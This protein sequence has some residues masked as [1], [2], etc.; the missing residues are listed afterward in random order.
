VRTRGV[1]PPEPAAGAADPADPAVP[2]PARFW[3]FAVAAGLC[4]AGL[5]TYGLIGYH[6]VRDDLVGTAAV[7]L[8]YAAAMAAEAVAALITGFVYDRSGPW[9][10]LGLPVLVAAV[11]MLAFG[12]GLAAVVAGIL[13]WGAATGVQDSTVKALVADLVPRHRRATAYGL[14]AAVQGAGALVGGVAAGALYQHSRIALIVAVAVTQA[15][16]LLILLLLQ[17]MRPAAVGRADPARGRQ[18]GPGDH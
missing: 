3:W 2:L 4:T 5:V 1:A 18:D 15:V 10:L 13:L 6:L 8:L 16:A 17:V 12:A 14:F 11:P 9:I 7:P